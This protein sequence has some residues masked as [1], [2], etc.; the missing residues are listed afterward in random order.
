MTGYL[1][2]FSQF[3]PI[4]LILD[5]IFIVGLFGY[6]YKKAILKKQLWLIIFFISILS[7]IDGIIISPYRLYSAFGSIELLNIILLWAP[8]IPLLGIPY[9]LYQY[10]KNSDEIWK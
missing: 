2:Y 8:Y 10:S 3:L 6:S 9:V 4:G 5:L 7:Y 1:F